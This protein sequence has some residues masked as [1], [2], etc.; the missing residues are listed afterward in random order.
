[1]ARMAECAGAIRLAKRGEHLL[2]TSVSFSS[3]SS[4]LSVSLMK[5]FHK[6]HLAFVSPV[7]EAMFYGGF[8][9]L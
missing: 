5:I 3:D 6:L 4:S 8:A 7:F 1:M 9:D 2:D